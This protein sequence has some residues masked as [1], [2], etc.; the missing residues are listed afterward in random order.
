MATST[1]LISASRARNGA[2]AAVAT[3][4]LLSHAFF[5][6]PALSRELREAPSLLT[7]DDASAVQ[8]HLSEKVCVSV[9]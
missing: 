2:F 4:L 6:L 3:L 1:V 9:T 5:V 7:E 8:R